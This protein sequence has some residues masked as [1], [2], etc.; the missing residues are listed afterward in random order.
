MTLLHCPPARAS[1]VPGL[2]FFL[3]R[4]SILPICLCLSTAILHSVF[5]SIPPLASSSLDVLH[6]P[7][8]SVCLLQSTTVPYSYY[9]P[10]SNPPPPHVPRLEADSFYSAMML[11]PPPRPLLALGPGQPQRPLDPSRIASASR[12]CLCDIHLSGLTT[13]RPRLNL[14]L[15]LFL[16]LNLPFPSLPSPPL[17]RGI[18]RSLPPRLELAYEVQYSLCHLPLLPPSHHGCL[19]LSSYHGRASCGGYK[20]V[21][22][23]RPDDSSLLHHRCLCAFS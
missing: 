10:R 15:S 18:A 21:A 4:A 3:C 14:S 8:L 2:S 9:S 23:P 22:S 17:L 1:W 16:F 13:L 12:L 6:S 11:F 5:L 19:V 20:A 7:C